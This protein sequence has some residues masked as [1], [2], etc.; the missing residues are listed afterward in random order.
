MDRMGLL[1]YSCT[2]PEQ[3]R[4]APALVS[5]SLAERDPLPYSDMR[6]GGGIAE[7]VQVSREPRF[8]R[9][10]FKFGARI[11]FFFFFFLELRVKIDLG[12]IGPAA[13][14]QRFVSMWLREIRCTCTRQLSQ[15]A[16]S[17]C[18]IVQL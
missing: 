11:F 8:E 10:P 15:R 3:C 12:P 6:R 5:G 7:A 17:I 13:A 1:G 18:P 16:S 9:R 14:A 4:E 2:S